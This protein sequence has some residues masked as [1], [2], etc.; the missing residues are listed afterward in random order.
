MSRPLLKFQISDLEEMFAE[1]PTDSALLDRLQHELKHRQTPRAAALFRKVKAAA[2]RTVPATVTLV[3]PSEESAMSKPSITCG[4]PRS[5]GGESL[6]LTFPAP[7]MPPEPSQ[8]LTGEHASVPTGV[9]QAYA[10]LK[11]SPGSS[12]ESVELARRRL[13]QQA[14]PACTATMSTRDR[15]RLNKQAELANA[16]YALLAKQRWNEH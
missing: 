6:S 12:W 8:S 3:Q 7:D 16:A 11:I 4:P 13:V 10:L 5:A 9:G 15:E 14:S 1:S 2:P